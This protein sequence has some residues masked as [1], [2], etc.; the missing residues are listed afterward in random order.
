MGSVMDLSGFNP[1]KSSEIECLKDE[2]KES[3]LKAVLN[4]NKLAIL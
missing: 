3:V 4:G 1:V 2:T